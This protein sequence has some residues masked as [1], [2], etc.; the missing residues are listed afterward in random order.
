MHLMSG[1]EDFAE[2]ETVVDETPPETDM[3]SSVGTTLLAQTIM[4]SVLGIIGLLGYNVKYTKITQGLSTRVLSSFDS[5]WRSLKPYAGSAVLACIAAF[6]QLWASK[7]TAHSVGVISNLVISICVALLYGL[8][9]T[10]YI[11]T[12]TLNTGMFV[13]LTLALLGGAATWVFLSLEL[14][15]DSTQNEAKKKQWLDTTIAAVSTALA[16]VVLM[17]CITW[18]YP[19]TVINENNFLASLSA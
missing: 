15:K 1:T 12:G 4:L 9:A 14:G 11:R 7:D 17:Q 10:R 13:L 8:W 18:L 3:W 19:L 2:Q 6:S 16:V 5:W